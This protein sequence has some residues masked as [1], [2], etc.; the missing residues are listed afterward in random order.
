MSTILTDGLSARLNK[1]LVYDKQL[2]SDTAA[3]QSSQPLAGWYV[4]L[5]DGAAGRRLEAGQGRL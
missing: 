5:G 3:F 2:A 1:T 4:D